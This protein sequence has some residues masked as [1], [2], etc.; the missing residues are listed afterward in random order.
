M[1]WLKHLRSQVLNLIRLIQVD[2]MPNGRPCV[3]WRLK[4]FMCSLFMCLIFRMYMWCI[5]IDM[6][7]NNII[8]RYTQTQTHVNQCKH[9]APWLFW[10]SVAKPQLSMRMAHLQSQ[11]HESSGCR[12]KVV[13]YNISFGQI[14]TTSAEVTL[15][16]GLVRASLQRLSGLGILY[17]NLARYHKAQFA[18]WHGNR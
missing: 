14:I 16:C 3:L 11:R 9:T 5:Y 13:A 18:N 6:Y 17:S 1:T 15:N 2:K 8:Y 7:I 10:K 12:P 4:K